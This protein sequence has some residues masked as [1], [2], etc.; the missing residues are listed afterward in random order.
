M[1]LERTA[2]HTVN[3]IIRRVDQPTQCRSNEINEISLEQVEL[4]DPLKTLRR[5]SLLVGRM[6]KPDEV[7]E[8]NWVKPA[9]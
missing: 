6:P 7:G 2:K 1:V 5:A 8:W 9:H 3:E 4:S